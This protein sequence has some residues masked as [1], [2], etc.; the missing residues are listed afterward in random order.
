[1]KRFLKFAVLTLAVAVFWA[2]D[3]DK[4]ASEPYLTPSAHT[5]AGTWQL[6]EWSGGLAPGTYVYVEFIR[7]DHL[8]K[9]YQNLD[10]VHPHLLTGTFEIEDDV[11]RGLYDYSLGQEWSYR[12]VISE[13]TEDRMVWTAQEDP[14]EVQVFV[15]CA[16][17][18]DE[19]TGA[20]NDKDEE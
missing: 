8:Y 17:I 14:E 9:M 13:L 3:D 10:S 19:I 6:A 18:P 15:R 2:C 1:M 16:S 12:Y 20:G 5:I 11:I 4:T 7:K